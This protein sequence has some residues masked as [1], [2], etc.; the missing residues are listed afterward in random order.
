MSNNNKIE[1]AM[2]LAAGLGTRMRPIT[3]R[4]PKPLVN[5][6]GKTLLDHALDALR[7]AGIKRAA[8]NVH[9]LADQIESHVA[10]R[11]LPEILISDEREELLDS[12]G[13]VKRAIRPLKDDTFLILNA[14][15]FWVDRKVPNLEVMIE[16]WDPTKMDMLLLVSDKDSAVGFEGQGDFF[17]DD[18][19][20]LTRRGKAEAAPTI[21][22]GAIIAKRESFDAIEQN[23]FSLNPMF[24]GAISDGRLFGVVL[25]GL[26]LHVGTPDAIGEAEIAITAYRQEER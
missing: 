11:K 7:Q 2:V 24:D 6:S 15:S 8:V 26:W 20:R 22:A 13:G 1:E 5:V 19:G 17:R 3:D 21:Y 23:K 25:D 14:D 18:E 4:I 16:A 12:G 9:Y 10:S